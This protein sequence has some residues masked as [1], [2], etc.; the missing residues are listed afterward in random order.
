MRQ[1]RHSDFLLSTHDVQWIA[2]CDFQ[3]SKEVT[4]EK[5]SVD[6]LEII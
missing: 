5:Q 6:E 3:H 2:S 1:T 4:L